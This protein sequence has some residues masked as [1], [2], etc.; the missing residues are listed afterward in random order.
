MGSETFSWMAT[1][2]EI[3]DAMRQR[4]N[5]LWPGYDTAEIAHILGIAESVVYNELARR[6]GTRTAL[7]T[8]RPRATDLSLG[9]YFTERAKFI[10]DQN[11]RK[12]RV[13][14]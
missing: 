1:M 7:G 5:Q 2:T 6:N 3:T 13:R 11:I 9:K 8:L 14:R 4:I 12:V 10:R